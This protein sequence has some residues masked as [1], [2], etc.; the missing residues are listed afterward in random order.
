MK[1]IIIAILTSITALAIDGGG[2]VNHSGIYKVTAAEACASYSI[3]VS[4]SKV[5]DAT[6][7]DWTVTLVHTGEA[8]ASVICTK[9]NFVDGLFNKDEACFTQVAGDQ[10]SFSSNSSGYKYSIQDSDGS[11]TISQFRRTGAHFTL[12]EGAS[13]SGLSL[14]YS[15]TLKK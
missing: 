5:D 11:K 9:R 7:K 12:K 8:Q 2:T 6:L 1:S 14:S 15:Y 3:V 4:C 13:K 10:V